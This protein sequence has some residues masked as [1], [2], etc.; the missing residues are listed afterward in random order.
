MSHWRDRPEGGNRFWLVLIR[1]VVLHIGRGFAQLGMWPTS[2]YFFLVRGE[3]RRASRAWLHQAEAPIRGWRGVLIHI[4]TFAITIV[5]RVLFLSGRDRA[6]QVEAVG[7]PELHAGLSEGR[8]AILLG[9]HLGSFEAIRVF[10]RQA[11]PEFRQLKVVMDV[12]QNSLITQ[13]LEEIN[14]GIRETVID[15]RQPGPQIMLE[16]AEVVGQGG[17]VA[18]LAD[19]IYGEEAAVEVPFFGRPMRLPLAPLAMAASLDVPVFLVFGLYEG[20]RRYRL[21]FERLPLPTLEGSG[22]RERRERLNQWVAAYA[23]RLEHYARRYPYNW[24]NFY[25]VWS[26]DRPGTGG[27][28]QRR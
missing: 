24:F 7:I 12:A 26:S 17:M 14:P 9:S 13:A 11:P 5:D 15:A 23:Q 22:R 16:A 18:L 8:G 19:R 3:E 4:Y 6:L 21:V 10:S 2:L 25:D 1:W 28:G 27:S 20:R